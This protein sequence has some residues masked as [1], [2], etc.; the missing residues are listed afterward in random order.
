M[1]GTLV[2]PLRGEGVELGAGATWAQAAGALGRLAPDLGE[3][4]RRFASVQVRKSRS[5]PPYSRGIA[6]A[7]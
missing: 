5:A 1:F 2:L 4:I 3:L 6:S 7:A